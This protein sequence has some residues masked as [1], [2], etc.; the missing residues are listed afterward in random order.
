MLSLNNL[1]KPSISKN[2]YWNLIKTILQTSAFWFVFLWL[3]PNIIVHFEKSIFNTEFE[4]FSFLGWSL[5]IIFSLLGLWSG[6]TMSWFG[7]GTPL[8]LDCPQK[9]VVAGPYKFVRNPM[10]VAGIGQGVS[11]GI[12]LG[13]PLIIIYALVGAFLWHYFVRPSEETDLL[14]RFG[15]DY[16]FYKSKVKCWVPGFTPS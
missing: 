15:N 16:I 13:S 4:S 9:L 8:P 2:R 6:Y 1:Y 7:N 14:E 3:I 12:I 10:A 5:F 11:V